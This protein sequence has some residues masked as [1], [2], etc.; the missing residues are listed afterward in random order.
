MSEAARSRRDDGRYEP[1]VAVPGR[2]AAPFDPLAELARLVGQDDPFRNVFRPAAIPSGQVPPPAQDPRYARSDADPRHVGHGA[3]HD[4]PAY[5]GQDHGYADHAYEDQAHADG[6]HEGHGYGDHDDR[7]PH[8][9]AH[10][11]HAPYGDPHADAHH[12]YAEPDDG[13][14]AAE[15]AAHDEAGAADGYLAPVAAPSPLPDMWARGEAGVAPEVDHGQ[16]PVSVDRPRSAARRPV[17]V[18]AAVLLLTGGGLGASFLAKG[19]AVSTTAS[20]GTG[21]GA[22]TIMAASGPT[23]V[24]V[25]DGSATAPEDQD[26]ELLNK[27][28]NLTSGPVKIVSSQEQPADLAQLPKSDLADG[29]RPLPPPSPSPFPEP[30]RVK[31]FVVHP[32]GSMLS[33][34]AAPVSSSVAA[35][36]PSTGGDTPAALPATP[37]TA[38]RGGTTPKVASAAAAPAAEPTIASL[39]GDP[40]PTDPAAVATTTAKPPRAAAAGGSYGVQLA[41]SPVEADANAAFARLK[42][43]YPAQL[44]ALTATVHKAE[45]GDKPVYRVRVGGMTQDEAKALCTQLQTAGGACLVM[46]N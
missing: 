9:G 15:Q 8:A 37:K 25:D 6:G 11:E 27:S 42:K 21:R 23:K 46:H 28:A 20:V 24:K 5:D 29:A 31:T 3:S 14:Y 32:D 39:S 38:A 13:Y 18:L 16:G 7:A 12:A 17:A 1:Q 40:A 33:G 22:P 35:P 4:A 2:E 10:D 34:D 43:K 19:G 36:A 30:K 26:A 41:S 44:G 45:T